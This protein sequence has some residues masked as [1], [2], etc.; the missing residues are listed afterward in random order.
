MRTRDHVSDTRHQ[1]Q[2][3]PRHLR[4]PETAGSTSSLSASKGTTLVC[5]ETGFVLVLDT[6]TSR[7]REG[8]CPSARREGGVFCAPQAGSGAHTVGG[9]GHLLHERPR[10]SARVPERGAAGGAA[11]RGAWG[12]RLPGE[13]RAGTGGGCI[14][15]APAPRGSWVK[16]SVSSSIWKCPGVGVYGAGLAREAFR[17]D[18]GSPPLSGRVHFLPRSAPPPRSLPGDSCSAGWPR[19]LLFGALRTW[20]LPLSSCG[21]MTK[22]LCFPS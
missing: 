4:A 7:R 21:F 16:N 9:T 18:P 5:V 2:P 15:P 13:P 17:A 3:S 10:Q 1:S 8:S 12:D 19:P 14:L 11:A 20:S 22:C 6:R